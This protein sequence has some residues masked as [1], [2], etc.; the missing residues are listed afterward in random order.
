M[1]DWK[2]GNS[3]TGVKSRDAESGSDGPVHRRPLANVSSVWV[4]KSAR[5]P[6]IRDSRFLSAP[7]LHTDPRPA[8][9][10]PSPRPRRL[11][12]SGGTTP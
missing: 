12:R 9:R 6:L 8:P 5:R 3:R 1:L 10:Y 4:K 2:S 7:Y 11:E